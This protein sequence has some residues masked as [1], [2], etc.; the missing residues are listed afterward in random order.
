M[1]T[2]QRLASSLERV[3]DHLATVATQ[4]ACSAP[5][6][7]SARDDAVQSA[8]DDAVQSAR[9][10]AVR[11]EI[12]D[13][14]ARLAA[15]DDRAVDVTAWT[16]PE[17]TAAIRDLDRAAA[18][19]TAVRGRLLLAEKR[20]E[21]SVRPGDRD[22]EA[23]RARLT[24]TGLGEARREVRQAEAMDAMPAV[25]EAVRDGRMPLAHLDALARAASGASEAAAARLDSA[26]VQRE[27][28][29]LA[30]RQPLREFAASAARL[31]AEA[32]PASL[33]HGAA[34][35]HRARFFVMSHQPDGT[36]L[37]GRLDRLAGEALRVALAATGQVPD[38][39]RDKQQADA[40]ALVALAER[41]L[42]GMAGVRARG[43]RRARTTG[44]R[45]PR[46]T[47]EPEQR[48]TDGPEPRAAADA[49]QDVADARVS[50][51]AG[52]PTVSLL[53]PAETFVEL[54]EHAARAELM[55][56]AADGA[57]QW[58]PVVPATLEDGTPVAMSQLARTLCDCE[59]G[60]I[61][62]G[63]D[64]L[65]MDLG[66]TARLYTG[67][68]RRAVIVRDRHCAWNGCEVPAAFC[69]VHHIRW[70]D[71]DHGPTSVEN[72]V[73]LC[74]HHHGVM[75]RLDLT[76]ERLTG[77]AARAGASGPAGMPAPDGA[78]GKARGAPRAREGE[79]RGAPAEPVRY[80]FR[81]RRDGVAVNAPPAGTLAGVA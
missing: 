14:A 55:G 68:Q 28:V 56:S 24:R 41:A 76:A 15:L 43:T 11:A 9:D 35:Q 69:E 32:D 5:R 66:R 63:A 25:A 26:E 20:A 59:I 17:R 10:D 18:L 29:A 2:R 64:G 60:R 30:G 36:F 71:R 34:A 27:L 45:E 13:V 77:A 81:R 46:A 53:V 57:S 79:R 4:G 6:A 70:W 48:N 52:R 75:H 72:G 47:G 73:L 33:E 8:R 44:G 37:R 1:L 7:G 50:G 65:P 22:F 51:A 19:V 54:R 58:R 42:A 23:A 78:H 61:V 39:E 49:E 40:D 12:A 21:T 3:F 62:I 31:V 80:R 38:G 74:S 67:A 16:A